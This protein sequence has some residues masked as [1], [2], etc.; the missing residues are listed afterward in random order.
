MGCGHDAGRAVHL[1]AIKIMVAGFLGRRVQA[2]AQ[3]Q[4]QAGGGL[5]IGQR[6]QHLQG[7]GQRVQ[8]I[9]KHGV[10]AVAGGLDQPAPVRP[11]R[12]AS[13]LVVAGQRGA[14]ALGVLLPEPGA[15]LDVGEQKTDGG[16]GC[17]HGRFSGRRA[18]GGW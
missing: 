8:R 4:R 9:V 3:R 16:V 11:H 6:V 17:G 14:H 13:N 2:A 10:D 12:P 15:A 18:S 5:W 1:G 7:G